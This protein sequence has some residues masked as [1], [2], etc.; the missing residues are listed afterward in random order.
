MEWNGLFIATHDDVYEPHDDTWLLANVVAARVR[1]GDR[2]L[3]VGCGT[4]VVA[5]CAA[6]AGATV[7]AVDINPHAVELCQHNGKQ[8]QLRI[9]A[10]EAD[11]LDGAGGPFD[12]IAF[13]PPYLPTADDEKVQGVLNHAFDGGPDGNQ[14][15]LRFASQLAA[16]P[17]A[18]RPREILIVHSSLS[19]PAPLA[20]ALA[21]LG[22]AT[23]IVAREKHFME[24]L[25]VRRFHASS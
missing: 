7:T 19:D 20:D 12:V 16:R 11:L 10:R 1:P 23:E 17:E 6:R 21:Q 14:V 15:V 4:G 8:N 24:E 9:A 2:F 25:W 22:Y 3:E 18:Q 5:M 13:N